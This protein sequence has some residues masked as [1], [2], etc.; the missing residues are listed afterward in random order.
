MW[1]TP[2]IDRAIASK[3]AYKID[4]N[5]APK[6]NTYNSATRLGEKEGSCLEG[7]FPN[8]DILI[9]MEEQNKKICELEEAIDQIRRVE[10]RRRCK[11]E[12]KIP[13][14]AQQQ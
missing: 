5:D 7:R 12:E 4:E 10:E 3:L 11:K 8:S 1:S 14:E 2:L 9:F 13:L 6:P